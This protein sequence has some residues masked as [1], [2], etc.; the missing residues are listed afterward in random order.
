MA[1]PL[2]FVLVTNP[3]LAPRR[4]FRQLEVEDATVL[5]PRTGTRL[6]PLLLIAALA[7]CGKSGVARN[8]T[9]PDPGSSAANDE[10][11]VA[12]TMA[13]TP[14]LIEDALA[15]SDAQMSL[16]AGG[17][18]SIAAL[19]QPV[20]FWRRIEH[21]ERRFEIAFADT[22]STGRP[23]TA[24]VTVHKQLLGTFNILA[25]T[26]VAPAAT[27]DPLPPRDSSLVVI[28]KPL[29]D[30]WVR[31]LLLK[32]VPPP[33]GEPSTDT[34]PRWR[35]AATSSVE[36][37]SRDAETDIVSVRVQA[38]PLDT[39]ITDPHALFRLRRML[40]FP[41]DV[42]VHLTVTT[43]RSDDVVVLFLRGGRHRM[44]NNG[45]NTYSGLF[46]TGPFAGVQHFG[47]NALSHGTLFDDTLPYDSQS[48]I[49]PYLVAPSELATYV[50]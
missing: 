11:A 17:S 39:V 34:R 15:E 48:W 49:V 7:G 33:P 30:H 29:A 31:H 16:D 44:H 45:D 35:V 28:H 19:I 13:E 36:I 14:E 32:R 38:G 2:Q 9:E 24:H 37:T 41:A 18:A 22:D 23:T 12:A 43:G 20:T 21:A 6:L 46:H 10:A 40:R 1:H 47:V 3:L 27:S 8:I 4:T 26:D 25:D 50:P 42:D 5:K